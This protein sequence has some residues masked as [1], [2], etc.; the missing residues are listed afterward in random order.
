MVHGEQYP[1]S[2]V[3]LAAA[4]RSRLPAPS[5]NAG[6]GNVASVGAATCFFPP[7]S[8]ADAV[9]RPEAIEL[10][11]ADEQAKAFLERRLYHVT[12][13]VGRLLAER[14]QP[15]AGLATQLD[16]VPM[17]SIVQG[18]DWIGLDALSKPIDRSLMPGDD[19]PHL[20]LLH[21]VSLLKISQELVFGSAALGRSH[22]QQHGK[23]LLKEEGV[24]GL[25]SVYQQSLLPSA[26]AQAKWRET[27]PVLR[28]CRAE[29]G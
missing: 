26:C 15:V 29:Y 13:R 10:T 14:D 21:R 3:S 27:L 19:S 20:H 25:P 23:G 22:S 11:Y 6:S 18:G 16:R 12:G 2:P 9:G 8:A 4:S 7:P 5:C 24:D 17:P 1:I 28:F